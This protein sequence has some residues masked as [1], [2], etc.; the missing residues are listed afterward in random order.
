MLIKAGSTLLVPRSAKQTN[1]VSEHIADNGQVGFSPEVILKKIVVK[2]RK[3]ASVAAIAKQYKVTASNVASWNK[4]SASGSFQAKQS[5]VLYVP[6]KAKSTKAGK[7]AKV[8]HASK[9][10]AKSATASKPARKRR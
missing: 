6:A 9:A 1:D 3:A 5:V 7:G 4:I 10:R 8:R 2:L